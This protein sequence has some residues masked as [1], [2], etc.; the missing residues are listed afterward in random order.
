MEAKDFENEFKLTMD[1][2]E[3][4]EYAKNKYPAFNNYGDEL[5]KS[6]YCLLEGDF[7]KKDD[8]LRGDVDSYFLS[9]LRVLRSKRDSVGKTE[10]SCL[11][12]KT[13]KKSIDSAKVREA[14]KR[15]IAVASALIILYV[16]LKKPVGKI[17]EISDAGDRISFDISYLTTQLGSEDRENNRNIVQQNTYRI[18]YSHDKNGFSNIA[19]HNDSIACDILKIALRDPSLFDVT[20]YK[21]YCQMQNAESNMNQVF[22]YMRLCL[23]DYD[24]F[25]SC[26]YGEVPKELEDGYKLNK[27]VIYNQIQGNIYDFF[28]KDGDERIKAIAQESHTSGLSNESKKEWE[29][30]MSQYRKELRSE[31]VENADAFD[32]L[33]EQDKMGGR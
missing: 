8:I 9:T 22:N 16:A 25:K 33:V 23:E 30:F 6:V 19:Y 24:F 18:P 29:K 3:V 2:R 10:E 27:N 32:V 26:H 14:I 12:I 31:A 5:K 21:T 11:P 28:V 17:K 20:I 13:Q 15:A 1:V 7:Y 4:C